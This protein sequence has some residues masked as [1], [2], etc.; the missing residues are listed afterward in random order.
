MPPRTSLTPIS[1]P[2]AYAAAPVE[3]VFTA[4]DDVDK[5]QFPLTGRELIVAR[6]SGAVADHTITITSK[7]NEYGRTRNITA[8]TISP[9]EYFMFGPVLTPG[10]LQA[11]GQLYLEADDA[12]I[13]FAIIRLP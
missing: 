1:A 13:E 5:N 10:W 4:A 12:E 7:A 9:G 3:L 6:N 2:G 8:F 11:D